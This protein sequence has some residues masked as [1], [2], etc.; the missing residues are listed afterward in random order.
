MLP[1]LYSSSYTILATILLTP[2]RSQNVPPPLSSYQLNVSPEPSASRLVPTVTTPIYITFS[3]EDDTI[4]ILWEH[5]YVELWSLRIRLLPGDAKIMD[6]SKIW[7]GWVDRHD[8]LSDLRSRQLAVKTLDVAKG[9]YRVT[10]LSAR[11]DLVV[12]YVSDILVEGGLVKSNKL[13]T[14]PQRNSRLMT[15]V[16]P[17]MFQMH[18]GEILTCT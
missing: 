9:L 3:S 14:L 18:N 8:E 15:P 17:N 11:H 13:S 12:D 5:G 10:T 4:G 6:P 7:S 16:I 2:F 1:P